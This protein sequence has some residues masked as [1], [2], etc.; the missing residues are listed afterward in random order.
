ML[1]LIVISFVCFK[2][3]LVVES[4][5]YYL[6]VVK[7][8]VVEILVLLMIKKIDILILGCIYYLLL[9]FII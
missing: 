7:K 5:E 2:F 9:C 6:F 4:N 3:V 8:I 1:E